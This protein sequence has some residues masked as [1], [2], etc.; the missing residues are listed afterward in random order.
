MHRPLRPAFKSTQAF[1]VQLRKIF[2]P[3]FIYQDSEKKNND[4]NLKSLRENGIQG[5]VYQ[6]CNESENV[7]CMEISIKQNQIKDNPRQDNNFHGKSFKIR[8]YTSNRIK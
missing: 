5:Q 1:P 6:S 8:N 3:E 2:T 4:L 7:E